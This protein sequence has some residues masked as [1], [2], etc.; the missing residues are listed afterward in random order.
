[1]IEADDA[2]VTGQLSQVGIVS[3]FHFSPAWMR[4]T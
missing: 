4:A 2:D 1:M 3:V